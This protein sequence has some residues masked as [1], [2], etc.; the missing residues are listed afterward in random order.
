MNHELKTVNPYFTQVWEGQKRFELRKND[1]N[2]NEG[3]FLIL[4]EYDPETKKY[5]GREIWC[6]ARYILKNYDGIMADYCIIQLGGVQ[7]YFNNR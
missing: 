7:T 5:S 6:I 2:F 1:R 4:K 3:D